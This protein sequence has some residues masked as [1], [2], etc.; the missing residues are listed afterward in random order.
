M[1]AQVHSRIRIIPTNSMMDGLMTNRSSTTYLHPSAPLPHARPQSNIQ[2]L[3][4]EPGVAAALSH[5]T[6]FK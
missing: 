1:F 2:Y 5:V 3:K 4:F 6:M